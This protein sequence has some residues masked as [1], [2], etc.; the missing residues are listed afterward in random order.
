MDKKTQVYEYLKNAII[1][2]EFKPGTPLVELEISETLRVS[3][4]PIREALRQLEVEGLV[5]SIPARGSFVSPLTPYDLEEIYELRSVLELWALERSITRI[6]NEELDEVQALFEEGYQNNSWETLHRADYMLHALI[7]EKA[8]S[9]RLTTFLNMLSS[10]SERVR[11]QSA[12]HRGRDDLSYREHLNI[13]Q[14]IRERNLEKSRDALRSHLRSV[15]R[16]ASEVAK[17]QEA[18]NASANSQRGRD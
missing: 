13:I 9:K 7:T 18:Q 15:A 3:R 4:S 17:M 8:W 16:S 1:M 6:E 5:F 10:Q 14:C 11:F 2:N 12:R